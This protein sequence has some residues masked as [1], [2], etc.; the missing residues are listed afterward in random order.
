MTCILR[1][2]NADKP[3]DASN[4]ACSYQKQT[5]RRPVYLSKHNPSSIQMSTCGMN[6]AIAIIAALP[7]YKLCN[8]PSD[9]EVVALIVATPIFT[10]IFGVVWPGPQSAC[11][12]DYHRPPDVVHVARDHAVMLS[13]DSQYHPLKLVEV[14]GQGTIAAGQEAEEPVSQELHPL[15]QGSYCLG[16]GAGNSSSGNTILGGVQLGTGSGLQDFRTAFSTF[17]R[18]MTPSI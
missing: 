12:G 13:K 10:L 17:K 14:Q 11:K 4:K 5:N 3:A 1:A 9:I 18:L 15:S 2:V 8:T 7:E 16:K 6:F